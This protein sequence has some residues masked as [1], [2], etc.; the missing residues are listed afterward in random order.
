MIC[1]LAL[2][3]LLDASRSIQPDQWLLQT[4][5]HADAFEAPAIHH[6]IERGPGIAVTAIAFGMGSRQLIDWRVIQSA[7]EARSFAA[8]LRRADQGDDTGTDIGQALMAGLRALGRAPCQPD[9]EVLDLV[10]D[11]IAPVEPVLRARAYAEVQGVKINAIGVGDP[12][13]AEWLRQHAVTPGGFSI[14]VEDWA[15]FGP[16]I[17]GK[18]TMEVAQR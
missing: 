12:G 4:G 5:G 14:Q 9:E 15:A 2:V 6:A 18:I 17:R 1:A 7:A 13:A 3:L 8:S 10:T 16:A 11:G